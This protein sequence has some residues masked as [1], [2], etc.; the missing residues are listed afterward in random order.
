MAVGFFDNL[1][2]YTEIKLRILRRFLT[3]WSAKL[4]YWAQGRN[5]MIWY[6]D[7]F[8]GPGKYKDGNDGSPLLGLRRAKQIRM[9]KRGYELACFFVEKNRNHWC[10]LHDVSEPFK[11]DGANIK[12]KQGEFSSYI[13]QIEKATSG[14]PVL[15]FVDPFG[16]S[17]LKYRAFRPFIQREAPLDL[18]LTFQHTAVHRLAKKHPHLVT[19]AIG[20][21]TW[22]IGWDEIADPA[23]QTERVLHILRA[24][25]LTDG[26]FLDVVYYPIGPTKRSAPKYFLLFASRHYD[27]FELWNDEIAQEET[28]LSS[29]EYA[30]A[31]QVSFLPEVDRQIT[32]F[33]LIRKVQDFVRVSQQTTRK[34]IVRHFVLADCGQYHTKDIKKAVGALIQSGEIVRGSRP[35]KDINTDPLCYQGAS[36]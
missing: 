4:G 26:G 6:V 22:K 10:N 19:E 23:S 16:I 14:A 3:P 15:L 30:Q 27:A 35:T 9:E 34:K 33:N 28:T 2:D 5:G 20:S 8:A 36:E 11:L 25:V 7:G 24:N 17:A 21:D 1:R 32:A 29:R 18:I 12:D 31:L 13:P